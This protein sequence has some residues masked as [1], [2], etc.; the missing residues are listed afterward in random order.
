[1]KLTLL[2]SSVGALLFLPGFYLAFKYGWNDGHP[3]VPTVRGV[4]GWILIGRYTFSLSSE[5][6]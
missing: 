1:M 3:I 4:I 6:N 2:S 5:A